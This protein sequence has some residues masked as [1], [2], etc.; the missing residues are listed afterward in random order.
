[1]KQRP[2]ETIVFVFPVAL[3]YLFLTLD[4]NLSVI[5]AVDYRQTF[6]AKGNQK[7]TTAQKRTGYVQ[8][9]KSLIRLHIDGS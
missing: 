9:A 4:D 8:T 5:D 7:I 2:I 3:M 1:M 6:S